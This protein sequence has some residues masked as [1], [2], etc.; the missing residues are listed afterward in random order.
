MFKLSIL[1]NQ[2]SLRSVNS[3]FLV[4]FICILT[5]CQ[6]K[7]TEKL[8][9]IRQLNHD[10]VSS[11][12]ESVSSN[13]VSTASDFYDHFIDSMLLDSD[14]LKFLLSESNSNILQQ[15]LKTGT[16]S[17]DLC[18]ELFPSTIFKSSEEELIPIRSEEVRFRGVGYRFVELGS[19]VLQFSEIY[20]L[21]NNEVV[22]RFFVNHK[23]DADIKLRMNGKDQLLL[24]Y[25]ASLVS[26]TGI[27]WHQRFV[28]SV[29]AKRV[30]P[31]HTYP[32]DINLQFP[33]TDFR[34]RSCASQVVSSDSLEISMSSSQVLIDSLGNPILAIEDSICYSITKDCSSVPAKVASCYFSATEYSFISAYRLELATTID[35]GSLKTN[36]AL[37]TYFES[38]VGNQ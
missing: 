32:A 34:A 28:F 9:A 11:V 12:V 37:Q 23:G 8:A 26:G 25:T 21:V 16:I 35:T 7:V 4:V 24:S 20:V 14:S 29:D 10:F 6:S 18:S 5:S 13:D 33:W 19:G 2:V 1:Y 36:M 31:L 27:W 17:R 3:T 38:Q 30:V 22:N 15:A